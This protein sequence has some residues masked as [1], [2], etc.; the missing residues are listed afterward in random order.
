M[1][2]AEAYGHP[3]DPETRLFDQIRRRIVGVLPMALLVH[4]HA[5]SV[6]GGPPYTMQVLFHSQWRSSDAIGPEPAISVNGPNARIEPQDGSHVLEVVSLG[7]SPATLASI[8][9]PYVTCVGDFLVGD[10]GPSTEL[11]AYHLLIPARRTDRPEIEDLSSPGSYVGASVTLGSDQVTLLVSES[12]DSVDFPGRGS[13]IAA[14]QWQIGGQAGSHV[15]EA[16]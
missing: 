7:P 2:F 16:L 4:D 9:H 10:T 5:R 3:S 15:V 11:H 14:L 8:Q 12:G 13:G 6:V 1:E